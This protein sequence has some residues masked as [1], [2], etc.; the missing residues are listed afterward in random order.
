M[1]APSDFKSLQFHDLRSLASKRREHCVPSGEPARRLPLLQPRK[2]LPP[3]PL[4][5][6]NVFTHD[7][8][9]NIA[10]TEESP[11]L[12]HPGIKAEGL[13]G[14]KAGGPVYPLPCQVA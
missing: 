6:K 14:H 4:P 7:L 3:G 12:T 13:P 11:L 9:E 8:R 1:E 5:E 10:G 2:K